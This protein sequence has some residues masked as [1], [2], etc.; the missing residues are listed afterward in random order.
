MLKNLTVNGNGTEKREISGDFRVIMIVLLW[1]KVHLNSVA[2]SLWRG[3][4]WKI[5]PLGQH[6]AHSVQLYSVSSILIF[7]WLGQHSIYHQN[8]H[9]P[10]LHSEQSRATPIIPQPVKIT[11]SG[12]KKKYSLAFQREA[13]ASQTKTP[14]KSSWIVNSYSSFSPDK[15]IID[16]RKYRKKAASVN[17][18][19]VLHLQGAL[20]VHGPGGELLGRP[21]RP[22]RA[23]LLW[24]GKYLGQ[25]VTK[26][27]C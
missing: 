3:Q 20:H 8:W 2:A 15:L 16:N 14:R 18:E 1:R 12:D 21:G 6:L 22:H 13:W 5:I 23:L 25:T 11:A 9:N 4:N 24:G 10:Q 26:K 19:D 17:S 7:M 27:L